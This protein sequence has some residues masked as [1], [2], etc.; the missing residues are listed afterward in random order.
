MTLIALAMI[1]RG[2]SK[3]E[4]ALDCAGHAARV[5]AAET[6]DAS[7]ADYQASCED[8]YAD[9]KAFGC[10]EEFAAMTACEI[11]AE[12]DYDCS[13]DGKP[14]V[15]LTEDDPCEAEFTALFDC[16]LDAFGG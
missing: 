3:D 12:Y 8:N 13:G 7:E 9:A 5:A 14:A 6:C 2:S 1:A 4:D 16:A 10:G 15:V 11:A